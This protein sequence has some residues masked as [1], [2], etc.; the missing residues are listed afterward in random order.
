[1]KEIIT[2][3]K[4]CFK[5]RDLIYELVSRD[6]KVRYRRSVLGMLW[7]ILTP[8]LQMLVMALVF[9]RLFRFEIEN[10]VVYLLIGN[11]MFGFLSDTT[12]AA[13][14]SIIDNAGLIKKVYIPKCLFPVT[15]TL[16]N[17]VN[18]GFSLI[19]LLF[20]MVITKSTFHW[21]ILLIVIPIF[22]CVLFTMGISTLLAT[23]TV[24]FRDISHLYTVF[25]LLWMYAT[26]IFYPA[27]LLQETAPWLLTLNPMYH[28]I[29]YFRQLVLYGKI[30]GV[31]ENLICFAIGLVSLLLGFA[32]MS[33]NQK[34]FILFV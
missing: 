13:L 30:P 26:P 22:Y 18:L 10:Y 15:K 23:Y 27:S 34:K 28:F 20:V 7:T 12:N 16:S 1:M 24:F 2:M 8:I 29:D 14:W 4:E 31:Q 32:A 3:V 33:R 25:T 11:I 17:V 9:S 6:I 5:F 19:S 21:T